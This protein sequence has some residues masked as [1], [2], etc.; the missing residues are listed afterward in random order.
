MRK[1]KGQ[2]KVLQAQHCVMGCGGAV[3]TQIRQFWVF[4]LLRV[5]SGFTVFM[6]PVIFLLSGSFLI[7]VVSNLPC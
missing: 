3:C 6:K 4:S 2:G 5:L 7:H 1:K